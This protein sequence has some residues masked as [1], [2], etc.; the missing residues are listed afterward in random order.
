MKFIQIVH[1]KQSQVT[2]ETLPCSVVHLQ[3]YHVLRYTLCTNLEVSQIVL[4][5]SIYTYTHVHRIMGPTRIV[6]IWVNNFQTE[7]MGDIYS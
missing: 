5:P 1:S 3:H 2:K 4:I 7:L 6:V